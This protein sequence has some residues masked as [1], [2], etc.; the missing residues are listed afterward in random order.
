MRIRKALPLAL[1]LTMIL[2]L[3]ATVTADEFTEKGNAF[4]ESFIK[5]MNTGNYSLIEPYLSGRLK[6]ELGEREFAQLRDFTME[7]YG[8]LLSFSFVN[9]TREGNSE[10]GVRGQ[11]REG[12]LSGRPNV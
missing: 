1:T 12:N 6:N 4:M 9:E 11:G 8:K 7:N 2:L 10:A 5:A 3:S